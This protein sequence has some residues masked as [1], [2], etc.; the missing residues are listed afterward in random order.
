MEEFHPL[1]WS[2]FC[3][4]K[5]GRLLTFRRVP[6]SGDERVGARKAKLLAQEFPY[7]G[8]DEMPT[9]KEAL[10]DEI[11]RAQRGHAAMHQ[12]Y[13]SLEKDKLPSGSLSVTTDPLI[14]LTRSGDTDDNLLIICAEDYIDLSKEV[15]REAYISLVERYGAAAKVSTKTQDL[16]RREANKELPSDEEMHEYSRK[17]GDSLKE[18]ILPR[19]SLKEIVEARQFYCIPFALIE[20]DEELQ[21]LLR[22]VEH[23]EWDT[24]NSPAHKKD[25]EDALGYLKKLINRHRLRRGV[26]APHWSLVTEEGRQRAS[27]QKALKPRLFPRDTRLV[28]RASRP[29]RGG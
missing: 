22:R 21:T 26:C 17:W 27:L 28:A 19:K 12:V 2:G 15:E 14:A 5:S 18:V 24:W 1:S 8:T 16:L 10:A 6:T 4:E 13:W 23:T 29:S 9:R 11:A 20:R 3:S 25:A 7:P